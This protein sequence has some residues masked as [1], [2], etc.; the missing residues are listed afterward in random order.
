MFGGKSFKIAHS[1]SACWCP[2]RSAPLPV[3][4]LL[5]PNLCK[6]QVC[7]P[8]DTC[9]EPSTLRR[10]PLSENPHAMLARILHRGHG[11]VQRDDAGGYRPSVQGGNDVEPITEAPHRLPG[12]SPRCC[13]MTFAAVVDEML[14]G[15][16][17]LPVQF[18]RLW[19]ES[20][21]TAPERMLA[22]AVLCQAAEDVRSF[23]YAHRRRQQRLYMDA[24]NWVASP[25]RTWPYSFLNLCDHLRLCPDSVRLELLGDT[26]SRGGKRFRQA[27][28][29]ISQPRR[30]GS[31]TH[32]AHAA[33]QKRARYSASRGG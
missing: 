17:A 7:R 22:I 23:R 3:T 31:A 9:A 20:G 16:I 11:A 28:R 10:P 15:E 27:A 25:D 32:S 8:V 26:R 12:C 29:W 2:E 24:Y 5:T 19:H 13:S 30:I 33:V 18:Q 4:V 1:L 6:R 14:A 21:A